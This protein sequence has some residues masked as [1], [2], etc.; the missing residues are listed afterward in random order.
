MEA[1]LFTNPQPS[2]DGGVRTILGTSEPVPGSPARNRVRQQGILVVS[3]VYAVFLIS[4]P[5]ESAG[6]LGESREG[7]ISFTFTKLIGYVLFGVAVLYRNICFRWF[8]GSFW[9]LVWYLFFL[10]LSFVHIEPAVTVDFRGLIFQRCQMLV[11]FLIAYNIHRGHPNPESFYQSFGFAVGSVGVL[12]RFGYGTVEYM[13]LED[14]VSSFRDDPN[15]AAA[16]L[17]MGSVCLIWTLFSPGRWPW[18]K[19]VVVALMLGPVVLAMLGTGSRGGLVAWLV[20]LTAMVLVG[21]RRSGKAIRIILIASVLAVAAATLAI[22]IV[23]SYGET[24]WERAWFDRDTAER[25]GIYESGVELF[26]QS[27]MLGHGG[28]QNFVALGN[29]MGRA[30]VDTHN[31]LLCILTEVGVIGAL[32]YLIVIGMAI[33]GTYRAATLRG[34]LLS[35]G[36]LICLLA[37]NMSLTWQNRKLHWIVLGVAC[38]TADRD[39]R[40]RQKARTGNAFPSTISTTD[41]TAGKIREPVGVV[42]GGS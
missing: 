4:L 7:L 17:A 35:W 18:L 33:R 15:T 28:Y 10:L 31:L 3:L 42:A 2:D 26:L 13:N 8:P 36:L 30:E 22:V 23:R 40:R 20:A 16:V 24:R 38:A 1:A 6:V 21:G 11:V 29:L 27:P 14:R 41:R 12:N 39:I 19:R 37:V 34:Q 32:P 5:F 25:T 9:L